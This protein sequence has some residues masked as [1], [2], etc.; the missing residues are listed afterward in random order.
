MSALREFHQLALNFSNE[1]SLCLQT[2][3]ENDDLSERLDAILRLQDA[4]CLVRTSPL[5]AHPND[6]VVE[7][8][9]AEAKRTLHLLC[10]SEIRRHLFH[11]E[12]STILKAHLLALLQRLNSNSAQPPLPPRQH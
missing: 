6:P 10:Q 2:L 4:F 7:Y 8:F 9:V 5:G 3:T 1:V 12:R 11:I